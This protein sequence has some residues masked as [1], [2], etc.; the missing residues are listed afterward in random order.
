MQGPYNIG[1][2]N[3][4]V[5]GAEATSKY[6]KPTMTMFPV[7][8][9]LLSLAELK[10]VLS[11]HNFFPGVCKH[12]AR[13]HCNEK[14]YS[15]IAKQTD[16]LERYFPLCTNIISIYNIQCSRMNQCI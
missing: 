9:A 13:T 7:E 8:Y 1:L 12:C 14:R 3:G 5:V 2:D 11:S 4:L 6:L 10:V 16:L 15:F